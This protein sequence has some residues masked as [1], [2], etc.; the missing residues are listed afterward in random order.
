[1]RPV[2]NN[3]FAFSGRTEA[4]YQRNK[5]LFGRIFLS[6][7]LFS[8]SGKTKFAAAAK[9]SSASSWLESGVE[10]KRG[11]SRK[12]RIWFFCFNKYTSGMLS[13]GRKVGQNG[14]SSSGVPKVSSDLGGQ[15]EGQ[16]RQ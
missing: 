9:T 16:N 13:I 1:M 7:A 11:K 4:F 5:N 6:F 15:L 10:S 2:L 12:Q 8:E 3:I 14:R